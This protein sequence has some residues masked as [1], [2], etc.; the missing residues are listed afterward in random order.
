MYHKLFI[1]HVVVEAT[2][3][4]NRSYGLV[5]AIVTIALLLFATGSSSPFNSANAAKQLIK[6]D[7]STQQV[8]IINNSTGSSSEQVAYN[9]AENKLPQGG[10]EGVNQTLIMGSGP[11]VST[12]GGGGS[13][14]TPCAPNDHVCHAN[15]QGGAPGV[16]ASTLPKGQSISQLQNITN[17]PNS[18][19]TQAGA[20]KVQNVLDSKN[21][22]NSETLQIM[23]T[24][25]GINQSQNVINSYGSSTQGALNTKL[26]YAK[27]D[28]LDMEQHNHEN[29]FIKQTQ[30]STRTPDSNLL[31]SA[32]NDKS[33]TMIGDNNNVHTHLYGNQGL[34]QNQ[35][36]SNIGGVDFIQTADN[37]QRNYYRGSGSTIVQDINTT[38]GLSQKQT[39]SEHAFNP[40]VGILY[41]QTGSNLAENEETASD[42]QTTQSVK[43][44]QTIGQDQFLHLTPDALN[45]GNAENR[46]INRDN[47]G[48]DGTTQSAD[49]NQSIS[50]SQ[51]ILHGIT[52][53]NTL[54]MNTRNTALNDDNTH[55]NTEQ[56][57]IGTQRIDSRQQANLSPD[58][59]LDNKAYNLMQNQRTSAIGGD[60]SQAIG[61]T[62]QTAIQNNNIANTPNIVSPQTTN[63]VIQNQYP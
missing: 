31:Q 51:R 19:N 43:G 55:S 33:Q 12:G 28:N 8:Q 50:Q 2:M 30:T 22:Q 40:D 61:P 36:A 37:T 16:S 18:E 21:S 62:Q 11:P 14:S 45:V 49:V 56:S 53:G 26:N 42:S 54:L 24:N 10:A 9:L 48:Q 4:S 20:N 63:N 6:G 34:E 41:A 32:V 13:G 59:I 35:D 23:P 39:N 58:S 44:P 3:I 52:S 38:Q 1:G 29:Q 47:A 46:I 7:Q 17:S 60:L 5:P 57:I 25:Q 15:Q 27:G